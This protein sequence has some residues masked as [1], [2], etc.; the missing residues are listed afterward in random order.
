LDRR[1]NIYTFEPTIPAFE[2]MK[3]VHALYHAGTVTGKLNYLIHFELK[4]NCII[5]NIHILL[6]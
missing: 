1:T 4:V 2:R 6:V 3:I 5:T